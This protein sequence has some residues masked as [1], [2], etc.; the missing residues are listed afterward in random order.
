MRT[1]Q[2]SFVRW[3]WMPFMLVMVTAASLSLVGC[4]GSSSA[5]GPPAENPSATQAENAQRDFM[6]KQ[7]R[8][9][10]VRRSSLRAIAS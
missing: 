6:K 7:Q 4:G 9:R 8:G 5:T 2:R 3:G 10:K 1:L